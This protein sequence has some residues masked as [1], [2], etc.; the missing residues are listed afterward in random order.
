MFK[1]LRQ[2]LGVSAGELVFDKGWS[3]DFCQGRVVCTRKL[4]NSFTAT[5]KVN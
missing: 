3:T 5:E 4:L 1:A 2:S